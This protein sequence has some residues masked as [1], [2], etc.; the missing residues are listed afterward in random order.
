MNSSLDTVGS[1][2]GCKQ[3]D[4]ICT[5]DSGI[6]KWHTLIMEELVETNEII[7]RE[8]ERERVPIKDHTKMGYTMASDGDG[9]DLGLHRANH[10]GTVKHQISH[11]IKTEID[12]GVI[13]IGNGI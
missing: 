7:E 12:C 11:T 1:G 4:V 13:E 8:R 9:I 10:R 3:T 6:S 2:G 5:I